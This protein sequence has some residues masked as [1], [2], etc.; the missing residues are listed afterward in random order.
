MFK[1]KFVT[2]LGGGLAGSE[3]AYQVTRF[4]LKAKLL[5]MRPVHST[6]AH[7]TSELGELVCSNSLKSDSMDNASGVLKEEMRR[8]GSIIIKA[9]DATRV[10]AGKALAVDRDAFSRYLTKRLHENPLV[11]IIREEVEEIP[12]P[13]YGPVIIAT[14]PLTSPALSSE[15]QK[16]TGSHHLYFYDAISPIIDAEAIDYSKVFR[17]SRYEKGEKEEGDYLN[18]PLTKG[19][20]FIFVE[21]LLKAE[22]VEAH[23]FEKPL[24][25]ESCLPI[26]VMAERGKDA[27][28]FGPMKPVGLTNRHT[29]KASFAVVQLRMENKEGTIYNMVGFQTKLR[30]P[31]QRRIFRMIP[32][33]EKA[34]FMR[35]GSIHRNTYICS[36]KLLHPTLQLKGKEQVFFAGQIV[37][38]EGY[39]ESAAMGM[40]AGINAARIATEASPI[41]PLP[42]TAIGSLITYITDKGIKNFQPMNI[43]FGLFPSL[44]N[45]VRK[46]ER[47]GLIVERA[48]AKIAEFNPF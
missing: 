23:D 27:L 47:K 39:V 9:A 38:V 4:G 22:K 48:M 2:I 42:E 41:I 37:G 7:K 28:R 46:S 45:G 5:E 14:G 34:E 25:F 17:A 11:E 33:L 26:E 12:S 44:P 30:Y 35:Y 13:I 24:Y 3:A 20:Y 19:E 18:C 1:E 36:P 31:E 15:I 32:G 29:G 43:N 8:L 6:P 10:P 16:I 40:V 21:E